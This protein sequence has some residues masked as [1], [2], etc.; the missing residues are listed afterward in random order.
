MANFSNPYVNGSIAHRFRERRFRFFE[1]LMDSVPKPCRI[2]DVG[3]TEAF[4]RSHWGD[5][6]KEVE[7]LLLNFQE[8][9]TSCSYVKSIAGDATNLSQYEDRSFDL[10]H[11]N[12]VIEHVETKENQAKMAAEMLRVGE[13]IFV[14]TPNK[15]FPIEPHY[16]MAQELV[17][18]SF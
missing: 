4:W 13:R 8:V 15:Y 3:G 12:S 10:V 6:K 7:V 16:G 2:L 9:P 18:M 17:K 11:S 14:Q 1:S 5:V